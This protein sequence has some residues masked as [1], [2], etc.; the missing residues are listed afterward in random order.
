V[1]GGCPRADQSPLGYAGS[2]PA[3][4]TA[5][6]PTGTPVASSGNDIF[7]AT[8]TPASALPEAHLPL[9]LPV[10]GLGILAVT[11]RRRRR[12]AVA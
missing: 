10:M 1:T 6:N 11:L 9:V 5:Q 2:L 12:S 7:N 8:G 4:A 3:D